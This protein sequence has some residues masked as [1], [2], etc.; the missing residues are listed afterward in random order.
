MA[1]AI[2]SARTL[3]VIGVMSGTSVDGIDI[4]YI[5]F[6]LPHKHS[7]SQG[8]SDWALPKLLSYHTYDWPAEHRALVFRLLSHE[9]NLSSAEICRANFVLGKQ[10]GDT[11]LRFMKDHHLD[12]SNVDL[13]GSHGQTIW[14]DVQNGKVTSTLQIGEPSV[15]AEI[16]GAPS[17]DV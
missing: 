1:A 2:S 10:F 7:S 5:E 14:H 9:S 13:I 15:I 17:A 3:R 11:I 6:Q 16:T 12:R 4:G 8:A